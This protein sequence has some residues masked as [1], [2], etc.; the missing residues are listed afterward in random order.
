MLL[1]TFKA[2]GRMVVNY[3]ASIGM[4]GTTET[5]MKKLQ[6]VRKPPLE[7]WQETS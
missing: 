7:R 4:P 3:A 5:Q 1:A 2:I 6:V